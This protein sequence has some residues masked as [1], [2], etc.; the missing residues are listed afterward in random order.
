MVSRCVERC[1]NRRPPAWNQVTTHRSGYDAIAARR[2][3]AFRGR[4]RRRPADTAPPANR[5][6]LPGTESPVPAA[7]ARITAIC[8]RFDEQADFRARVDVLTCFFLFNRR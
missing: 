5:Q 7:A 1:R 3:A 6:T 2:R 8:G 4:P